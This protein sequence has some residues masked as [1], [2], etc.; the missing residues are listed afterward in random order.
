MRKFLTALAVTGLVGAAVVAGTSDAD[1]RHWRG[2]GWVAP[3]I[4][5]GAVLGAAMAAPYYY[6]PPAAYY[7]PDM[8]YARQRVWVEGRGWR[9]RRVAVPC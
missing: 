1:A 5:G 7:E 9:M 8:C 6:G 4:V 2:H 3:A